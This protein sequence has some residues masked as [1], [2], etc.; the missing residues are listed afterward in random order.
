[1]GGGGHFTSAAVSFMKSDVK[2]VE[3][4]LQDTV[5]KYLKDAKV[6]ESLKTKEGE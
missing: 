4:L 1:M 3:K 2:E 5:S 6:N